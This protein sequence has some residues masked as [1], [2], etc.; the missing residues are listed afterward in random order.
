MSSNNSAPVPEL[1]RGCYAEWADLF[2]GY[3]RTKLFY[4]IMIG[5]EVAPIPEPELPADHPD[6]LNQNRLIRKANADALKDFNNR[7]E[8]G[9]GALQIAVNS[10]TTL[11]SRLQREFGHQARPDLRDAWF[12]VRDVM[13][14]PNAGTQMSLSMAAATLQQGNMSLEEFAS[15]FEMKYRFMTEPPSDITKKMNLILGLSNESLK[16]H[17]NNLI[18]ANP[19]MSYDDLI[20]RL[21]SFDTQLTAQAHRSALMSTVATAQAE[22]S[23]NEKVNYAKHNKWK[24]AHRRDKSSKR[25]RDISDSKQTGNKKSK[26]TGVCYY[27]EKPNHMARDCYKL[28]ADRESGKIS[29]DYKITKSGSAKRKD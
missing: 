3:A 25:K 18:G 29:A 24:N 4:Q 9:F 19:N 13:E 12:M 23:A 5:T 6:A 22:H 1:K 7:S 20:T 8:I 17:A 15:E 27:C 2:N 26:F 14:D 10:I 11:K 21:H 16:V 28:K